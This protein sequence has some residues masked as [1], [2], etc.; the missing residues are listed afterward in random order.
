[1]LTLD[2]SIGEGGGQ[3]LRTALSLSLVTGQAFGMEK[4]RA[5][6]P[7]PGLQ[8]QHLAALNAAA[9]IGAAEVEGASQDSQELLFRPQQVTPGDYSFAVGTAGSVTLV[10]QTILPALMIAGGPSSLVLEGGTHNPMAPPFEFLA[11]TFLP[12]LHRMGPKVRSK[13][14][15]HGFYPAGGGKMRVTIEPA[16]KLARLDLPERG[17]GLRLSATAVVAN[18]PRHV[19]EREL[20]VLKRELDLEPQALHVEEVKSH[21]SG[22]TAYVQVECASLTEI[23]T[24]FGELGVR[25]E[26]VAHQLAKDVGRYL[27]SDAPVGEHLAD[28][29][30]LPMALGGGGSFVTLPLSS[31]ALTNIEVLK[32]FLPVE[33]PVEPASEYAV[34]VVVRPGASRHP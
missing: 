26:A 30:L 20:K 11:K 23:F 32:A 16:P 24:N 22:N 12:L 31:H 6:R 29:L 3:I 7:K 18:L 9:T 10:L 13:L 1:M 14:D 28:Q 19:A 15:R 5:G 34:R 27:E 4:I 21:G 2:G 25:A 17:S 8:P 33:I